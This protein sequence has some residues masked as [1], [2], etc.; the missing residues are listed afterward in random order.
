MAERWRERR[1]ERRERRTRAECQE[2][3]REELTKLQSEVAEE[4]LKEREKQDVWHMEHQENQGWHQYILD[5]PGRALVLK[6]RTADSGEYRFTFEPGVSRATFHPD[7]E[8]ARHEVDGRSVVVLSAKGAFMDTELT[9]EREGAGSRT[10]QVG[11]EGWRESVSAPER[12][13]QKRGLVIEQVGLRQFVLPKEDVPLSLRYEQ[14]N[15]Q[16]S[17]VGWYDLQ[18]G[19]VRSQ[20]EYWLIEGQDQPFLMLTIPEGFEGRIFLKRSGQEEVI[21][22]RPDG[23]VLEGDLVDDRELRWR[24]VARYERLLPWLQSLSPEEILQYEQAIGWDRA[25]KGEYVT[26]LRAVVEAAQE[27]R[28]QEEDIEELSQTL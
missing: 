5:D 22:V 18:P 28:R 27:Q 4:R 16:G 13:S 26:S 17:M 14:A 25:E 7:L 21:R 11:Q 23:A 15:D 12:E 10:L 6:Y 20:H 2:E 19:V 9:F 3:T 1:E 24:R 8:L